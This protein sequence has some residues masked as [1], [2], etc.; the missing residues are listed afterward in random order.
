MPTR[1]HFPT[2]IRVSNLPKSK[3]DGRWTETQIHAIAEGIANSCRDT[4]MTVAQPAM[5]P[6]V[7]V[8]GTDSHVYFDMIVD[9][10]DDSGDANQ[11]RLSFNSNNFKTRIVTAVKDTMERM[12]AGAYEQKII[13]Q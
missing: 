4:L 12:I 5:N 6:R 2:K 7:E 1:E 8:W 13:I 10:P 9:K 11:W 3:D